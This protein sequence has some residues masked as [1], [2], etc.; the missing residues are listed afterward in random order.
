MFTFQRVELKELWNGK[1]LAPCL[2]HMSDAQVCEFLLILP[3]F[4]SM[5]LPGTL[6]RCSQCSSHFQ[7]GRLWHIGNKLYPK[8]LGLL[9][10]K[11]CSEQLFS[12]NLTS[13]DTTENDRLSLQT[14]SSVDWWRIFLSFK[15]LSSQYCAIINDTH[16]SSSPAELSQKVSIWL[17]ITTIL[18]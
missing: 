9:E 10:R 16:T 18:K 6:L 12:A 11:W 4:K 13:P 3:S 8:V 5:I 17:L 2:A 1:S 15:S 14:S 7:K